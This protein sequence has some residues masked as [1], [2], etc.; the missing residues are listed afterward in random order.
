MPSPAGE[1]G[2]ERRAPRRR[3]LVG[4]PQVLVAYRD[5]TLLLWNSGTWRRELPEA[6]TGARQD[7]QDLERGDDAVATR[8]VLPDDDVAALLAT[9]ARAVHEHRIEDVLVAHGCPDDVPPGP[10]MT[11]ASPP[12][13]STL[14]TS[15][16][17]S[18][19][20]RA[21]RSRAMMPSSWSPSTT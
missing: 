12:F 13:E 1:L 15:V 8:G 3:A 14:T 11:A 6:P 5:G 7:V 17:P 18:S 16:E 20:A 19:A 21:S 4:L 10:S 9:H 2:L